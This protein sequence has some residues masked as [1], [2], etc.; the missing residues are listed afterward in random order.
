[1]ILPLFEVKKK[2]NR[3]ISVKRADGKSIK[4]EPKPFTPVIPVIMLTSTEI[5]TENKNPISINIYIPPK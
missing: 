3:K 5:K 1:M 4:N 2:K